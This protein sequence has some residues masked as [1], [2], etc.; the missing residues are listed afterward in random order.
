M[1]G[2]QKQGTPGVNTGGKITDC[3]TQDQ[4]HSQV[5]VTA[6]GPEASP[7]TSW[8]RGHVCFQPHA[9]PYPQAW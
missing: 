5:T 9:S 2:T 4:V 3:V 6:E 8:T 7:S 1:V